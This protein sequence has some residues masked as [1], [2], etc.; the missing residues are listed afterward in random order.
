MKGS[1]L[2]MKDLREEWFDLEKRVSVT[3]VDV[4]T[5]AAQLSSGHLSGPTAARFLAEHLAAVALLGVE[6]SHEDEVVSLQ[7]KCEGP[8]AGI[9]V[10]CTAAGLLRGYTEKKVLDDFDG[11]GRKDLS[12]AIGR[13]R[14]QIT[15]SVPGKILSQ[16]VS[17]S[18]DGYLAGSLQRRATM[19][20]YSEVEDDGKV[21][22]A[23]GV[24]VED[25]PDAEGEL[26]STHLQDI[27]S[28]AISSRH[29]LD[30]LGLKGAEK[31]KTSALSFGCRCS[32]ERIKEVLAA[33]PPE[34][35]SALE[36]D[37]TVV[38]HMCGKTFSVPRPL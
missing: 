18:L 7:M 33:M 27:K 17:S 2:A 11:M 30:A 14:Y 15:R 37:T 35:L 4:T 10:E 22:L 21:V 13:A 38:C 23:R 6:F 19:R 24:M 25:M 36:E 12:K 3:V 34:E 31:K 9:N 32:L 20:L 1:V 5:A 16:G 8:L 28:I 26:V 29:I